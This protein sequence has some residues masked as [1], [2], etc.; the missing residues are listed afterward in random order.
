M[1][2]TY[3]NLEM[4][5]MLQELQPLLS[6]RDIVGYAAARNARALSQSLTEY[7]AFRT[8]LVEKYGTPETDDTGHETGII[9]LK[10]DSP[11]FKA[12]LEELEPFNNM[13]HDVELMMV[14]YQDVIGLLS[15]EEILSIDWMLE[16]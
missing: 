12:F 7:T 10:M 11:N 13:A 14:K 16:D 1:K 6:R 9:S 2:K 15:G 5:G 3:R 4:A 8:Q